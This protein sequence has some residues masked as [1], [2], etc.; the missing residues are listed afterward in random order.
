MGPRSMPAKRAM[1]KKLKKKNRPVK[2]MKALRDRI[3]ELKKRE[4]ACKRAERR[5]NQLKNKF[6][7]I[8]SHELRTPLSIIK[9]GVSLVLDRIPGEINAEQARILAIANSN[10]DRLTRI[11]NSLLDISK[12]ESGSLKLEKKMIDIAELISKASA[13]F[14]AA[15]A[16][17]G[18]ELK[19]NIPERSIMIYA[20]EALISKAVANLLGNAL[21]F[22]EKGIVSVSA[23]ETE[24]EVVCS[25]SDTGIGISKDDLKKAFDKFQQFG[26]VAGS[27]GKGTGLGLATARGIVEMHGGDIRIESRLGKGTRL[28]FTLPKKPA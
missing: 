12:I 28:E 15:M 2:D 7:G 22:T 10:V 25:V 24:S 23:E 13:S 16:E 26:R 21:K 17:K 20:D 3:E 4:A 8:V 14:K 11:I 9:E 19:L 6:I 27:G 5:A 18:L 1:K